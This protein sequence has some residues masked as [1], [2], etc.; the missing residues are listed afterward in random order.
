V[1]E[2]LAAA[3]L[4]FEEEKSGQFAVPYSNDVTVHAH[5][6]EDFLR[7]Y[8]PLGAL[9]GAT[10]DERGDCARQA[11]EFNFYDPVGRLSVREA[12]G[13]DELYWEVQVPL[14][15]GTPR[16]LKTLCRIGAH[17]VSRWQRVLDGEA[18]SEP[19]HL[20][21]GGDTDA[22]T[23]R[24]RQMI[25]DAELIYTTEDSVFDLP[26]DNGVTV[27]CSIYRGVVYT[28]CGTGPM[29]GDDEHERGQNALELLKWNWG[30]PF[31]R[32][33]LDEN[34]NLVWES[35]VPTEFLTPDYL[36]ILTHACAT[37]VEAFREEY[38]DGPDS[39]D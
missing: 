14:S 4:K 8:V 1:R 15:A 35:Q 25:E 27:K 34:S 11:L 16:Y 7:A 31:G 23:A 26:Y 37:Q 30:D 12:D 33:S 17:Q 10:S 36:A 3:G 6:Y 2:L 5:Q 21:P 24:L 13:V 22:L 38:G 32:I 9:P 20:Y 18:L 28:H 29:P 39:E 19:E